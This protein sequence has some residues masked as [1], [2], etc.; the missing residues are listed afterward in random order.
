MMPDP[1]R[2]LHQWVVAVYVLVSLGT[3]AAVA[4]LPVH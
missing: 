2:R 1:P 3:I 4:L